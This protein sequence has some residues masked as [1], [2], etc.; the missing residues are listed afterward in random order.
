MSTCAQCGLAVAQNA[1]YCCFGCELCHRIR[2]EARDDH[3]ALLGRLSFTIVLAMIVMMLALFLYAED[4]FDASGDTE[5]A[6]L[7]STYRWASLVLATPVMALAGGPLARAAMAQLRV[8]RVSMDALIVVGALAAYV[9]SVDAVLRGRHALYFDSAAA[10]V[11]LAT[12]GR[13]LEATARTKA[14]RA[15]GPL[16]EVARGVVRQR[17]HTDTT[18][19]VAPQSIEP[20]MQI[21]LDAGQIV[22]VDLALA[23]ERAEFDL[24][25]LTGESRPTVLT[26]GQTVPAG[27]VP[28][29]P[30]VQGT[31]LRAS[32]DS[33]LE[34]LA[35]LARAFSENRSPTLAWAD[36]FASTLTPVVALIAAI[37]VVGWTNRQSFESGVVAGLAVVLAACPC[38]YAIASPL[39]HWLMLRTAFQRGVLIRGTDALEELA[40]IHTVAFDKTG[41]LTRSD[42]SVIGERIEA[43]ID[44]DEVMAI[45]RSIEAGNT[46]PAA[47]ALLEHAG[48][49]ARVGLENR[50]F[51]VGRGVDATD[52]RGRKLSISSSTDG[53]LVLAR[54]GKV[55][56]TFEI[57]E[58]IRPEAREALEALRRDGMRVLLL[59]GDAES[60]V[61][62]VAGALELEAS[63]RLAPEDKVRRI[64]A[65]DGRVAMVGD[66]VNDAPA[67]ASRKAS[68]TLGEST[69]LAKG[70]AQVTLLEPDLR[71][72]PWTLALARRGARLVKLLLISSTLYNVVF[73]GLA[74]QGALKPVWAG[75][76]MMLSSLLAV[77]VAVSVGTGAPAEHYE[78]A[79]EVAA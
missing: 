70:L 58:T 48:E 23:Q 17:T 46:H 50:V 33:A 62:R 10:A 47:R 44:R 36:R 60:R 43:S 42:P 69:Q 8:K 4:V 3:A 66:G 34:R 1:L 32:R 26:Q 20:G 28:L 78:L 57:D 41:T 49:G 25:V 71:L 54:D 45:V 19:P 55:V 61:R 22:P 30:L 76:S 52:E 75:V 18:V 13:W 74:A 24:A 59:S 12:F 73:V 15:L 6:W 21:E 5:M 63:A 64:E 7:R 51:V 77:G 56:A 37:T 31:A 16:L 14:S 2:A 27:A 65:L 72:V 35:N 40:R 11:V 38:S 53:A 39:V 68:F 29:T 9:L 67:L 79:E